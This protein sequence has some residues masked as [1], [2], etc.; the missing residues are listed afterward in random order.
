MNNG[1]IQSMGGRGDRHT[2]R[3]T[4]TQTDTHIN[5]IT[6]PSLRVGPSKNH[7]MKIPEEEFHSDEED[8]VEIKVS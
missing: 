4:H 6:R 1:S 7:R 5:T 2:C 3:Q 8:S